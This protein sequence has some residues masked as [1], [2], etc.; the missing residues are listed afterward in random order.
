MCAHTELCVKPSYAGLS[1][2]A[3]SVTLLLLLFSFFPCKP[4]QK[5]HEHLRADVRRGD[6]DTVSERSLKCDSDTVLRM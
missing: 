1:P 5:G 3:P 4:T 6:F 2:L